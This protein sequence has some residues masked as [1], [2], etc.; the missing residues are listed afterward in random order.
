[1]IIGYCCISIC[2]LHFIAFSFGFVHSKLYQ[3]LPNMTR[4]LS[5]T[6]PALGSN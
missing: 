5:I 4:K 2:S 6:T 3:V 1:M